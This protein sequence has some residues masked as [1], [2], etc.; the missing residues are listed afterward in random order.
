MH[1]RRAFLEEVYPRLA[2]LHR[3]FA[4]ART[5][6]DGL[7]FWK[8]PDESG[9]DNSPA[10]DEGT[11]AHVDLAAELLADA[12]EL[13]KIARLLGRGD[14]AA[15]WRRQVQAWRAGLEKMW[16]ESGRFFFPLKGQNR[17]PVYGIQGLF[18]LWDAQLRVDRRRALLA[19]LQD[20]AEFWS[21]FPIPSVSLRSP[22]FMT[23]KWFANTYGSPETGQRA[24]ERLQD[25]TSVYWRGP[26]WI[27][28]NAIIYEALRQRSGA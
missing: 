19:R 4:K 20:P 16:D 24:A 25:Y 7:P 8:Q 5:R 2:A 1:G 10:F 9:M 21:P 22:Q 17:V 14:E 13:E 3:W 15:A 6:P 11:D 12:Q 26:V 28:S 27:F 23:P 18:P